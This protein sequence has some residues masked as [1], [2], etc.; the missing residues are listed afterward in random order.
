MSVAILAL[1]T[2][3]DAIGQCGFEAIE[4]RP[5][6]VHVS[7]SDKPGEM[8]ADTLP[9]HSC[10]SVV[11]SEAFFDQNGSHMCREAIYAPL[12]FLISGKGEVVGV[13][14][15]IG[16]DGFRQLHET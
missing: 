11:H 13:P 2:K 3:P 6:N 7:I 4:V 14:R 15:V 8:L 10:L 5:H 12:E 9:H 1:G 16:A